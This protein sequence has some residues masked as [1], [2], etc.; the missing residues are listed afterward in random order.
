[1]GVEFPARFSSN[2]RLSP[3]QHVALARVLLTKGH[4][5]TPGFSRFGL[6]LALYNAIEHYQAA[7]EINPNHPQA[8]QAIGRILAGQN[9][10]TEAYPFFARAAEIK[11]NDMSLAG[12]ARRE[13][14]QGY[15][16][17][18]HERKVA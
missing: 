12:E 6:D 7:L 14:R 18:D 1:M 9:A 16:L 13:A 17:P 4:D 11:S 10:H 2:G 15:I 5:I 8:L 3:D